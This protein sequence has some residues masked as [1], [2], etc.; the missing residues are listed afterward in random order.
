M[1]SGCNFV[2]EGLGDDAHLRLL[3]LG[4]QSHCFLAVFPIAYAYDVHHSRSIIAENVVEVD[5]VPSSLE[6]ADDGRAFFGG[7]KYVD[8]LLAVYA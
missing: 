4:A 8:V 3:G 1:G 7:K 5:A 6:L 2:A